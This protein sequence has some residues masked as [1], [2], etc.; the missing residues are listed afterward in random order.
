MQEILGRFLGRIDPLEKDRIPTSVFFG[1]F[2]GGSAGNNLPVMRETWLGSWV[3][4]IP[5]RRERL[6]TPVF[7][8]GE[9]HG[10]YSSWGHKELYMTE[11]LSL[12]S[13]T[14]PSYRAADRSQ[15]LKEGSSSADGRV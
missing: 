1:F 10:L 8:A 3:G 2:P 5:W 7:W 4:K 6:P 14:G 11:R 15:P 13:Q 12:S 9:F